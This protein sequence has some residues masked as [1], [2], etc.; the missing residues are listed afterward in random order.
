MTHS[1]STT[2]EEGDGWR[3]SGEAGNRRDGE[4]GPT[5]GGGGRRSKVERLMNNERQ[6]TG[7]QRVKK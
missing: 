1:I 6:E 4:N 2:T 3:W 7:E 5:E